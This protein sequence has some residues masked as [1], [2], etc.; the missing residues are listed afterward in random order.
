MT[1]P[2]SIHDGISDMSEQYYAWAKRCGV[3]PRETILELMKAEGGNGILGRREAGLVLPIG[4][5]EPM[6]RDTIADLI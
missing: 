6:E 5:T 3:I 4:K 2:R 1:W